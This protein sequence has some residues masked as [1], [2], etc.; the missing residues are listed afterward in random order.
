[1][2][3]GLLS[4]PPRRACDVPVDCLASPLPVRQTVHSLCS[5][6]RELSCSNNGHLF[7][8]FRNLFHDKGFLQ[9]AL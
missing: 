9:D 5:E 3:L 8:A 4:P 7:I 1:M 6:P 2:T